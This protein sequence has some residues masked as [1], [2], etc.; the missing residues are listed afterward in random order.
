MKRNFRGL[1]CELDNRHGNHL[2][3]TRESPLRELD[4]NPL[5]QRML[6]NFTIPHLLPFS[7]EESDLNISLRY[8][9]TSK[10]PLS[11]LTDF[12]PSQHLYCLRLLFAI[13]SAI[14]NNKAYMLSENR[15]VLHQDFIFVGSNEMAIYLVYLPMMVLED[16]L[17]VQIS[18]GRLIETLLGAKPELLKT[19]RWDEVMNY[20]KGSTF[21]VLGLKQMLLLLIN[22]ANLVQV[23]MLEFPD[24][25]RHDLGH[26]SKQVFVSNSAT[27]SETISTTTAASTA[28]TNLAVAVASINQTAFDFARKVLPYGV[29]PSTFLISILIILSTISWVFFLI[30]PSEGL[31]TTSMGITLVAIAFYF[32][33]LRKKNKLETDELEIIKSYKD[34]FQHE[35]TPVNMTAYY[36]NLTLQT[37]LLSE[38]MAT[39]MLPLTLP[40]TIPVTSSA[41]LE[42]VR[43]EEIEMISL[44][45]DSFL[46]GRNPSVVQYVEDQVGISR[47]HLEIIINGEERLAKDLGS[48]NGSF[49][50]DQR[51]VPYQEYRLVH[52]DRIKL[53]ETEFVFKGVK[54]TF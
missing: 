5:E 35:E 21:S 47:S 49:L 52:E 48:K 33:S 28:A 29:K 53:A 12:G 42:V 31:F 25:Y 1:T 22:E 18:F 13:T 6:Q 24:S 27:T 45:G 17:P 2:V 10:R 15:F 23:P 16:E 19:A 34:S 3:I 41:T 39:V 46:I 8:H 4:L 43:G 51:M 44:V 30:Y 32:W 40:V 50:N 36:E 26:P 7:I 14:H 37:G 11:Q 38:P 20:C 9:F 54:P